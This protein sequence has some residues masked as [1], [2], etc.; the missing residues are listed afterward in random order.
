MEVDQKD[1]VKLEIDKTAQKF[2]K[3]HRSVIIIEMEGLPNQK[4][5]KN[6]IPTP[7]VIEALH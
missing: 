1:F 4:Y 2:A 6:A 3:A 5:T 7:E